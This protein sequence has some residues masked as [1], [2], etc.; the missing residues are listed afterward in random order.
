MAAINDFAVGVIDPAGVWRPDAADANV[1]F[2]GGDAANVRKLLTSPNRS[3]RQRNLLRN[4][5]QFMP[6]VMRIEP[7]VRQYIFAMRDDMYVAV[8]DQGA[9]TVTVSRYSTDLPMIGPRLYH[10]DDALG[11]LVARSDSAVATVRGIAEKVDGP[12]VS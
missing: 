5:I 11:A 2:V 8:V 3:V 6:V 9:V 10:P 4:Y 1:L 7:L 12:T